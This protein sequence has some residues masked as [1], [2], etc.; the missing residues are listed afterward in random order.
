MHGKMFLIRKK[1]LG[2]TESTEFRTEVHIR[3]EVELKAYVCVQKTDHFYSV[4]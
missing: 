2:A 4:I 3:N 1:Y